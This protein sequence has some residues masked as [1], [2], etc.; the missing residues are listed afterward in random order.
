MELVSLIMGS[1]LANFLANLLQFNGGFSA[2]IFNSMEDSVKMVSFFDFLRNGSTCYIKNI[3]TCCL[4][5]TWKGISINIAKSFNDKDKLIIMQ[6]MVYIFLDPLNS[7]SMLH[8][9]STSK[10]VQQAHNTGHIGSSTISCIFKAA[11]NTCLF[12]LSYIIE[13]ILKLLNTW[14]IWCTYRFIVK[15]IVFL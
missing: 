1:Q 10:H 12:F 2:T 3:A 11:N 4:G 7:M 15:S 14:I 5:V 13:L 6:T 8:T 9:R